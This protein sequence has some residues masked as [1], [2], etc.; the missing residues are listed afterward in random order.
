MVLKWVVTEAI[1][2]IVDNIVV[3]V[4]VVDVDVVVAVDG[5]E[6]DEV[7]DG[8][9]QNPYRRQILVLRVITKQKSLAK[10]KKDDRNVPDVG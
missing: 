3:V 5:D 9:D 7:V 10:R 8:C 1:V 2:N 4:V 6:D